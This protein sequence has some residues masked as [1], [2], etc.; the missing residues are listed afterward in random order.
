M[1]ILCLG[2]SYGSLLAT[3]LVLAGQ[4]VTL[5][6]RGEEAVLIAREGTRV[7]LRL[8]GREGLVELDSRRLSGRLTASVPDEIEPG[9]FDLVVLAM[10]EPQY[11][12]AGVRELLARIG[13]AGGPCLSIM[14]MPPPPFLARLPGVAVD[15]CASCYAEP[16]LWSGLDPERTTHSS[17]DPQAFRPPAEGLNV[18]EVGLP[19]NFKAAR[20]SREADTALL[21]KLASEIDAARFDGLE[22][23]V[24]LKVHDSLFVPLAKWPMQLA[25]NYRCVT[26]NG[27]RSIR[28]AVHADF[29]A[30]RAVY[31]WVQ[32]LCR[33]LGAGAGDEVPF[34]KY[35]AAAEQLA[36]PSSAAR[37]ISSGAPR[38]ERV[39]RLVQTLARQK[40]LQSVAVDEIVALVDSRLEAN[41][42]AAERGAARAG[43]VGSGH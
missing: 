27:I 23:P 42:L 41:R 22:V 21:R 8:K 3:K 38:I 20:F 7:R 4:E 35:A 32:A 13:E 29:G 40:G 9:R 30:S 16:A 24:K 25:G 2:A 14:N 1:R 43:G 34:E 11:S 5:A 36:R 19:T 31:E 28:D 33:S 17:P 37:A 12:G 26:A 39:D 6:C 10:Q 18:L 15:S